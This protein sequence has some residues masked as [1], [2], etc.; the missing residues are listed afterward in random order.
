MVD[1][2]VKRV[3]VPVSSVDELE[4]FLEKVVGE[5]DVA[6]SATVEIDIEEPVE[7]P[8][9]DELEELAPMNH[10]NPDHLQLAYDRTGKLTEA[11]EYFGVTYHTVR[12]KMIE[13]GVHEPREYGESGDEPEGED[14]IEIDLRDYSPMLSP[15]KVT[16]ALA[17]ARSLHEFASSIGLSEKMAGNLLR[18]LDMKDRIEN[19]SPVGHEVA[20]KVVATHVAAPAPG[21]G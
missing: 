1:R 8:P 6:I 4:K 11:A 15:T 9:A 21:D 12:Q 19:G 10:N 18:R 2:R 14:D 3:E 16:R 17:G 20:E 13:H 7:P 5:Y